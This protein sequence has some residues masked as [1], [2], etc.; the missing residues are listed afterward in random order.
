[1]VLIIIVYAITTPLVVRIMNSVQEAEIQ[2]AT[3]ANE[4][5]SSIRM[6]A[7]CGAEAKVMKRY[8][9]WVDESRRRGIKLSP[10][11]AAQQAP[12]TSYT[13]RTRK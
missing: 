4:I 11:V 8:E 10:V 2:A 6:V 13:P 7:A 5:F 1:M 9:G 12:S 3:V